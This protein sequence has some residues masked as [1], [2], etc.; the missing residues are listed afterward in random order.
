M[1]AGSVGDVYTNGPCVCVQDSA[2]NEGPPTTPNEGNRK[3]GACVKE[4]TRGGR[5]LA[6][7][8]TTTVR[9]QTVNIRPPEGV[10]RLHPVY[11]AV[12]ME[13]FL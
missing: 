13:G 3:R 6:R 7:S 12:C 2:T 5:G 8:T 4:H 1:S 10:V 11:T 9:I